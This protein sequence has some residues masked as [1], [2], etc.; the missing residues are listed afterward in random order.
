MP[1]QGST[2][3]HVPT[4]RQSQYCQRDQGPRAHGAGRTHKHMHALDLRGAHMPS[5]MGAYKLVRT[6]LSFRGGTKKS[7][8]EQQARGALMGRPIKKGSANVNGATLQF[9]KPFS[10]ALPC[11]TCDRWGRPVPRWRKGSSIQNGVT[12]YRIAPLMQASQKRVRF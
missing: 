1:A 7:H 11:C 12:P 3:Y 6:I 2:G 10:V 9:V 8:P 4:R 5:H